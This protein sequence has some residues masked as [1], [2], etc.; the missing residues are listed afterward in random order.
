MSVN[1]EE[2]SGRI[3]EA[4]RLLSSGGILPCG[5]V[6][7]VNGVRIEFTDS[8]STCGINF[9]FSRKKGFSAV[10]SGGDSGLLD[11]I[12]DILGSHEPDLP[13]GSW[14]GSDEAGKGDYM[15]PL[16]AAA[17]KADR[18]MAARFRRLGIVDSKNLGHSAVRRLAEEIRNVTEGDFAVYT[19]S[20]KRYNEKLAELRKKGMNSLDLLAMC[21]AE[22]LR[23]LMQRIPAPDL[24]IIDR[25]CSE[26]R[27]SHLLP[28][29]EYVLELRERGES[30]PA[31]AA[32]SILARDSYMHGLDVL[33]E[34]YGIRAVPGAGRSTDSVV[35]RY[36]EK[37]GE[38]V[39]ARAVKLHFRNTMRVRS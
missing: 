29:G 20:P 7:L 34:E 19:L 3:E 30:D 33:T 10:P 35:R 21:H 11:R 1:G 24:V 5:R 28:E 4:L 9:Y 23:E 15:G 18:S 38:G 27:I 17:V 22:A 13:E 32:A 37:H 16:S 6:E 31:V 36:V 2:L 12:Q 14:T 8:R 39:L 25:F 26:G